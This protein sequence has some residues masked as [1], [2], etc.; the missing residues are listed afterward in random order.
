MRAVSANELTQKLD[1]SLSW[2][3]NIENGRAA[4]RLSTLTRV[5]ELLKIPIIL[6]L[7][8]RLDQN[9][10][11]EEKKELEILR[12]KIHKHA[13]DEPAITRL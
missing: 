4:I 7:Q 13:M 9:L 12:A 11:D 2:L 6:T 10:T 1:R 3:S 5:C 8:E